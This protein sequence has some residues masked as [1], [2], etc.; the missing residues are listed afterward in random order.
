M[1]RGKFSDGSVGVLSSVHPRSLRCRVPA[2]A[3]PNFDSNV[4]V[5]VFGAKK[6]GIEGGVE[7]GIEIGGPR[8][9]RAVFCRV[10]RCVGRVRPAIPFLSFVGCD[11]HLRTNLRLCF[12]RQEGRASV[13]FVADRRIRA[14][15]AAVRNV[16]AGVGRL[17]PLHV[18][19]VAGVVFDWRKVEA[20]VV[21]SAIGR[22]VVCMA[23]AAV[24]EGSLVVACASVAFV[25]DECSEAESVV[26]SAEEGNWIGGGRADRPIES[27]FAADVRRE[28][29]LVRSVQ[30]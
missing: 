30:I 25:F 23:A 16:R 13:C 6:D 1:Q 27:P 26:G 5:S 14:A 3:D 12:Y 9:C 10:R 15:L 11:R 7:I 17:P 22:T 4:S 28:C 19:V 18:V 29:Q 2:A 8:R 20:V 21:R 24:A